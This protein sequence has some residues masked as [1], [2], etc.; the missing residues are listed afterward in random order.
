MH[1]GMPVNEM[2]FLLVCAV[3]CMLYVV[4]KPVRS[5]AVAKLLLLYY[6]YSYN[7]NITIHY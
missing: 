7:Y 4:I 5:D 2:Q 6:N 3:G 1:G